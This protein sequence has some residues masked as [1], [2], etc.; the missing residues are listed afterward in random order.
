MTETYQSFQLALYC[1]AGCLNKSEEQLAEE[2]AF[3]FR[4]LK[5]GKVYIENHRG[6]TSLSRERLEELKAFF[7]SLG[8]EVAGG[9]T[10]TLGTSYRPGYERILGGICYTDEASRARLREAAETAA[11]VFD[12]VILDDFFFTNCTC[13]DCRT[14]KGERSWEEFRLALMA[15]VSENVIIRP[16]KAV[17]PN[18]KVIIK[19]PNWNESFASAGYNTEQQPTLFDGI[20]TGTETRDPA[21]S[22]QHIPRYASYSL[23]RWME[24]LDPGRNGGGWFDA[25][26]CTY[27]DYYLEQAN[28]TA[29]SKARE[30]TLF[31]YHLLLDHPYV[32]ALGFQLDKLDDVTARLGEPIGALVY[33]PHHARGEDHLYDLLGMAGI[34][35]ELTPFFPDASKSARTLLLSAPAAADEAILEKLKGYLQEGGHA[36]MTSGFVSAMAERGITELVPIQLTG[37]SLTAEQY[38]LE[39]GICSF[40]EFYPASRSIRYPVLDFGTNATWQ[41]IVAWQGPTNFPILLSNP[42][43]RGKIY[44]L[45]IPEHPADLLHL[46]EAVITRI[47]SVF[48]E[49]LLPF[50]LIGPGDAGVFAY[51][52]SRFVLESFAPHT[53]TWKVQVPPGTELHQLTPVKNAPPLR[54]TAVLADGLREY[55]IQLPP[56]TYAVYE[57]ADSSSRSTK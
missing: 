51:D 18:V 44:T 10:P 45:V 22:Q 24:N 2:M 56:S 47:R 40:Q 8:L 20:Y 25:Y 48:T 30:L 15:E 28:L 27:T 11:A 55:A 37:A 34:P 36:V 4:H 13:D 49:G 52:N 3:F 32:P 7:L 43:G 19:Y 6:D 35:L 42:Y 41:E 29:F 12:E 5:V 14:R 31:C 50:R 9:I 39:T 33:K 21:I 23:M 46:P 54:E 57:W 16:A 38:A 53:S 1:T 17:N 26:D